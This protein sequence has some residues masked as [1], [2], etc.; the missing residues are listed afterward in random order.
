MSGKINGNYEEKKTTKMRICYTY[1]TGNTLGNTTE[2][3]AKYW[4]NTLVSFSSV[5]YLTNVAKTV[6]TKACV[7]KSG[8]TSGSSKTFDSF[9]TD[10]LEPRS[11]LNKQ[12]QT[13][14]YV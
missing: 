11:Y 2:P 8:I 10:D 9:D 14:K 12:T 3:S 7:D 5:V 6:N 4:Y 1:I 13:N